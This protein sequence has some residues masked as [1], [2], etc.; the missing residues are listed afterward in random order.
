MKKITT[1]LICAL[2]GFTFITEK[3]NSQCTASITAS[4]QTATCG[5]K[6]I[7]FAVGFSVATTFDFNAGS[8]PSGWAS[9]PF[10][11]GKPCN[12]NTPDNSNYF[13]AT[14]RDANYQR[15]VATNGVNVSSGGNIIFDMRFGRDDPYPGCEDPDGSNEGVYLQYSNNGGNWI[16]IQNWVPNYSYSGPLYWWNTYTIPVPAG[17]VG[18]NTRFRWFQPSNSGDQWDNWGLDDITIEAGIGGISSYAWNFGDGTTSSAASPAHTYANYGNFNTSLTLTFNN[19]TCVATTSQAVNIQADVTPPIAICKNATVYLDANG[20]ASVTAAQINNNSTDNCGILSMSV[21]PSTFTCADR[22]ANTVTLTVVDNFN[23][24]STCNATVTVVDNISP[25]ITCTGNI[26]KNNDPGVCGAV[27]TYTTPTATD[28]CVETLSGSQTFNYTGSLQNFVVP[29]GVTSVT[30]TAKGA[31]GGGT[32]NYNNGGNGASI[33]GT[34]NVT[35][36]Q[37]LQIVAGGKGGDHPAGGGGGGGGS[38]VVAGNSL[39]TGT[40]LIAAGGGG[41][42]GAGY[43]GYQG[44]G[45]HGNPGLTSNNGGSAYGGGCPS[46]SGS[47]GIAGNGGTGGAGYGGIAGGGGGGY[48]TTGT[49]STV[50]TPFGLGG[51]ALING[52]IGGAG[53]G[54]IGGFGGGAGGGAASASG[55]GGGGGYSGGAGGGQGNVWGSGGGGG[56]SFNNGTNPT[57]IAGVVS[58]HGSVNISWNVINPQTVTQTAGL[59][60]GSTFPIGTTTN[61]FITTDASNNTASCSF[62]VIVTDTENPTITCP[63]NITVNNDAG[64][65]GAVVNYVVGSGDNCTGFTIAQTA[66]LASGSTFPIGTTTNTFVVTDASFNTATCTFTV[67]VNATDTDNDGIPNACDLDD[68]NDGIVDTDECTNSNFFWSNP[69]TISGN[70]ASGTINGIG[71]TY[72]SSSPVSATSNMFGHQVFPASYN[73]PNS[74]PTIQNINVTNNTLTFASPMTNPVLVFASIGNGSTYV[75][76]TFSSP[77]NILWSTATTQNSPT[78]ITGNEGFA[79]VRMNGTFTSISFSYL[80]YENY[81]NF[82]FGADFFTF[83]D[84]DADG[85]NDYLDLDSD[86][87]GCFD[88]IEGGLGLAP[89]LAP[90]GI[91]TG[92]IDANGVPVVAGPQGQ[93]SGTSQ[94]ASANC[95]C[96]LGIDTQNPVAVAKNI[97]VILDATGNASITAAQINNGSSDNCSIASMTVVPNSFTCNEIGANTV[98]L[99]VTDPNGNFNTATATVDV[100]VSCATTTNLNTWSQ[101]GDPASGT[102]S[103]APDGSSVFQSINGNPTFF[104]SPNNFINGTIEGSFGVETTGDDD[105]IGFVFGYNGPYGAT[106]TNYDFLLFDWKQG[107]QNW[108]GNAY[109]GFTLSRVTGTYANGAAAACDLWSHSGSNVNLLGSSYTG[110]WTDNT[111]YTFKLEYTATNVKIY[112]NNTLVFNVNGTFPTGRF[113]FYN[114]S[115][116]EV[117]YR[118]FQQPLSVSFTSQTSCPGAN[119]GQ[120]TANPS[121]NGVPPFTY[122]WSNNATTQTITGLAPGNYSC[123][124]SAANCCTASNTVEVKLD[125]TPPTISCPANQTIASCANVI[126]DYTT[127]AIVNDNCGTGG[128]TVTQN[129]VAGTAIVGG[130]TVNVTLTATDVAT[131]STSCSFNV[132]RPD[133]TPVANDDAAIVCAGSSVTINVLGND[134]HPQNATLT[135]TSYT[136]PAS[137]TLVKNANNTFTYTAANPSSNPITFDYTIKSNDGVIP[138]SGNNHYY[139]W[140]PYSGISWNQAKADAATKTFNGMQGYLVTVTSAA[141]MGFVSAKLQGSGWMGASD[142]NYEGTWRWVTGP[143][144]LEDNGLGR[145]FS[146]QFKTGWCSAYQAPGVNGNYANWGAGEPNDCGTNLNQY[147]STDVNRGGE[148]WAHFHSGGIWNDYPNSVAGNIAGYIV[149]YGG[150]EPCTPVLTDDAT[151]TITVNPKPILTTNTT[152]VTCI[153]GSDGA[154]DLTVSNNVAPNAYNWSNSATTEDISGLTIGSYNVTVTDANSCS[155]TTSA[156]LIQDDNIPPVA[157]T[158]NITIN[159]DASGNASITAAQ[160]NNGSSDNCSITTMTVNPNTFNC[161]NVGPNTVTLTVTDPDGNFNT[162]TA[163]VTIVDNTAPVAQCQNLTIQLDAAGNAL[164]TSAQV[165]SGSSDACGIASY[166]FVSPPGYVCAT[167][168]EHQYFHISAPAGKV[169]TSIA[170]ASYGHPTGTCGN[171]SYACH[172]SNTLSKV[173]PYIIGHNSA[174]I[175][176]SNSKFGD[177]CPGAQKKLVV[178]ANYG[179][180]SVATT[181]KS[182]NCSNVGPNNVTLKVTDVNG[183]ISYCNAV[184]TVE[185]NVAP[186]AIAQNVTV[187]LDA[188]GNGATTA[189]AV[190][191]GSNDACG[192]ASLVLDKTAFTCADILTNP[193]V[194]TLTVTDNNGNVSTDQ[195]TVTVEDNILPTVLTNNVTINLDA[196]GDASIT[197]PMI[198][199]GSNDAC[200]VASLALDKTAFTCADIATNPNIVTLTVTDVNNNVNSATA[201]VTVVDNVVPI[202]LTQNVTIQLGANGQAS[203]TT[204]MIDAGSTDNCTIATLV[205]DKTLFTC[206]DIATNPNT[207][208]LTV[209]DIYGNYNSAQATVTVQDNII[210]TVLT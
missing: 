202:V 185:D 80:A 136:N 149:E 173:S 142:L 66:G 199:N 85:I 108:C 190:N 71:Y 88:A 52:A 176:V 153:G 27:V 129:P 39:T 148:H 165:N 107:S 9:S 20:N 141:E 82:A 67:T 49:N 122:L 22:G 178:Q 164:I 26:S 191:N 60:S 62:D 174:T 154:V 18:T 41:G 151:V 10:V 74:N 111:V 204:T 147:T 84:T 131:N 127:A 120:A 40:L 175:Y 43:W 1:I 83:C 42:G 128:I 133:I 121:T 70:T 203:I 145:H 44:A 206:A 163:V 47:G 207:V 205:L 171:Y 12:T 34:F 110:G 118:N 140:I 94:I 158:K 14:T 160:V 69:P 195:A 132:F 91:L 166:E 200:G 64:I 150:L 45:G 210:P 156:T 183:N 61:T 182:F 193:N 167:G 38:F 179:P 21:S 72:T 31:K 50:G 159:L 162:A 180:G 113:G 35:P 78:Q 15:F 75:P 209:T 135:I 188:S 33:T 58:G 134:T 172:A 161:S 155:N 184:I 189:A 169:F 81:V 24:I 109:A 101:Q 126:P 98:T 139:E 181:T 192:I 11:V 68:D 37:I 4:P 55:G 97:T 152:N 89:S 112:V 6:T 96:D 93:G 168:W 106:G 92:A 8:L 138:Y 196:N 105:F 125:E 73:V 79:I 25:M 46:C 177:P 54:G 17:A 123:T 7:N 90:N 57:N 2:L 100:T 13:W 146:N 77:V 124:I 137:G 28:N 29:Q 65:C 48:L 194:V 187:Q 63:A 99:T 102:W 16:G 51:N 114:F 208:T 143:E 30:I 144:G 5:N 157:A 59:P 197:V 198:D 3:A 56:G 53:S 32:V 170:F 130:A 19:T 87:D 76:I 103:V 115:Q 201:T 104:V 117:R 95:F 86:N 116:S 36:A 119:D 186:V 23:N